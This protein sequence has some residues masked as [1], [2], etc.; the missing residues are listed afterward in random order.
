MLIDLSFTS[1]VNCN[2]FTVSDQKGLQAVG[3]GLFPNLCLVNHDCWPNC[4]VVLNHG[5]YVTHLRVGQRQRSC[6]TCSVWCQQK[7]M[8][9]SQTG[10]VKCFLFVFQSI[11]CEYYVSHSTEVRPCDPFFKYNLFKHCVKT[12][13]A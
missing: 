8:I 9:Q 3:V 4:T 6:F 13:H 5:K 12:P 2:G 1:Q 10:W 7:V 11:G